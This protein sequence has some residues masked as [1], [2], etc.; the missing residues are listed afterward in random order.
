MLKVIPIQNIPIIKEDDN[1][2]K[3][4]FNKLQNSNYQ[5]QN[6][7]IFV[8]AQSIV[9]RAEGRIV[10][11][12]DIEPSAF[13][14]EI[15]ENNNKDPKHVEIILREAKNLLKNR[16]GVLVTETKHGFVCANSGVDK[17]NVPGTNIVSLLPVDP[18]K[19]AREIRNTIEKLS[20]KRVSVIISDTHNRPFRLGAINIA[21]GCSGINPI[22]NYSGKKDLFDYEL[23]TT[24]ISLADQLCSAAGLV[25]GEGDEGLPVIIISGLQFERKEISA[26]ELIRSEER[27]YFR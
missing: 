11:L 27:D 13:A 24:S 22:K 19:S 18:D 4:I 7:D 26:K 2:G 1:I 8:I 3:I 25:M 23:K 12:E 16:K 21:I 10:N 20:K 14:K 6:D 15:A 17:S 9:S 5:I